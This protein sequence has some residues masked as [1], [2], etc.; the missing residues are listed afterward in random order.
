LSFIF[1]HPKK[2]AKYKNDSQTAKSHL[3]SQNF[4]LNLFSSTSQRKTDKKITEA[5]ASVALLDQN[6]PI[7]Q[8]HFFSTSGR[9]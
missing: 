4:S 9:L 2:P 1:Q 6:L 3:I 8:T 5:V 7:E